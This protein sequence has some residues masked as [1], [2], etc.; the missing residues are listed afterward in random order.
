MTTS[1]P[2]PHMSNNEAGDEIRASDTLRKRGGSVWLKRVVIIISILIIL[3]ASA[4]TG[5]WWYFGRD[6][7]DFQSLHEYKPPQLSRVLDR[8]GAY[9]GRI[10]RVRR[11][12]IPFDQISP[13]MIQAL[14]SAEDADFYE[15]KGLDYRGI[16]RAI[17]N[18]ARAGKLKGSGSTI[19]QQTVKNILF[20]F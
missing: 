7:P 12:V 11:T 6:L 16:L 20:V 14:L 15:H 2:L 10:S 13:V 17:Y 5:V 3:G 19:T 1:P 18:S 4:L 8:H 9:L